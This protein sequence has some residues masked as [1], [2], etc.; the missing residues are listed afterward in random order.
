MDRHLLTR[1]RKSSLRNRSPEFEER[2]RRVR[3]G[4]GADGLIAAPRGVAGF[5]E[6][7]ARS[8]G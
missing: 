7:E 2:S 3:A 4:D 1:L 5:L 6:R 8:D